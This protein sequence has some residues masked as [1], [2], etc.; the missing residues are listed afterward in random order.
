MA[1]TAIP[2]HGLWEAVILLSRCWPGP[3]RIPK[4]RPC[5]RRAAFPRMPPS[6]LRGYRQ[7]LAPLRLAESA[8]V[9]CC[10]KS[11]NTSVGRSAWRPHRSARTSRPLNRITKSSFGLPRSV[12]RSVYLSGGMMAGTVCPKGAG[13]VPRITWPFELSAAFS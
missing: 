10:H 1:Q 2:P 5:Q 3:D 8:R 13:F 12:G 6:Q 7:D 11:T 4:A 9:S